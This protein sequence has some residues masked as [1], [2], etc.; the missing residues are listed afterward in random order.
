ME[1]L[2][3]ILGVLLMAFLGLVALMAVILFFREITGGI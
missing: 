3:N 1:T 2:E